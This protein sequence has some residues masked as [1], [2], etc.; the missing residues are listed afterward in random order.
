M[1]ETIT[2]LIEKLEGAEI[3]SRELDYQ[4][5]LHTAPMEVASR[6]SPTDR[7]TFFTTSLDAALALAERVLPEWRMHCLQDQKG[8]YQ[9]DNT[10][11]RWAVG[12]SE[13]RGPGNVLSYAPTPSLAVCASI[14]KARV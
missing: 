14:L 13:M 10:A 6:W 3:G 12:I 5:F 11:T 4:V 7:M 1:P 8:I 2:S 9:T